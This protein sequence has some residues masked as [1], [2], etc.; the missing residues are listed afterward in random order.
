MDGFP[1]APGYERLVSLFPLFE[2]SGEEPERP[3]L[4]AKLAPRLRA[5]AEKGVFL[6]TSSWKYEGWLGSIYSPDRYLSRGKFS[7]KRFQSSCLSEYAGVFPAVG[8]DFSFYQFPTADYWRKLFAEVPATLLFGLKTPEDVTVHTWP[9]HARYGGRAG[10]LNDSFLDVSLFRR[11]FLDRLRPYA[12]RVGVVMLEFGTFNRQAFADASSFCARLRPFLA[13]LPE[14]FRYGVEVRNAEYLCPLY[15]ETLREF[16]VAHVFNG[17][18]RMPEI[19][20]QMTMRGAFTA[21]FSAV[22]ALLKKGRS[23]E[24]AVN[25]FSPYQ[26]VQE[27]NPS[28]RTARQETNRGLASRGAASVCICEQS[29]RR[30]CA[31]NNRSDHRRA[32]NER[33][34]SIHDAGSALE[35]DSERLFAGDER[36]R[37]LG[38]AGSDRPGE[39]RSRAREVS[40]CD[41][42]RARRQTADEEARCDGDGV[43]LPLACLSHRR[44]VPRRIRPP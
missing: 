38:G 44:P 24:R 10:M 14:G 29:V 7:E 33:G 39:R 37:R 26:R 28:G 41:R 20:V 1:G 15:F 11:L 13:D 19:G 31:E 32:M 30:L 12:D 16:N 4:A 25:L 8:G 5:L 17:W 18:T 40:L 27:V 3:P 21:N 6:G 42:G 22:R 2:Q 23:Y 36:L 34:L 9:G 35:F 43:S